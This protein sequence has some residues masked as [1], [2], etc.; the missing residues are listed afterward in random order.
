MAM[1]SI[2]GSATA[3]WLLSASTVAVERHDWMES[4]R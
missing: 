2:E 4:K 1:E 3:K